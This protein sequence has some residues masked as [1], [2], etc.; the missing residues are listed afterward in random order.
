MPHVFR[1]VE[2]KMEREGEWGN[3]DTDGR[4]VTGSYLKGLVKT[5][6]AGCNDSLLPVQSSGR[7][8]QCPSVGPFEILVVDFDL[9][10]I[11]RE[12]WETIFRVRPLAHYFDHDSHTLDNFLTCSN[13]YCCWPFFLVWFPQAVSHF[14]FTSWIK[15]MLLEMVSMPG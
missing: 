10:H 11:I 4:T 13:C 15:M 5:W 2:S 1:D 14:Q 12:T 3:L 7:E 6:G 8:L 9:R